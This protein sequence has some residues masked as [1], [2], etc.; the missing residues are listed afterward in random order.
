MH[1]YFSKPNG[2]IIDGTPHRERLMKMNA[3]LRDVVIVHKRV[4]SN[5]LLK[6][7]KNLGILQ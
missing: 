2:P 4:Y 6:A 3:A 7:I 1:D 5:D